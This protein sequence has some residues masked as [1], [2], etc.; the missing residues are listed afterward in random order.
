MSERRES[1][2]GVI[3]RNL[4]MLR[5]HLSD[6]ATAESIGGNA[7]HRTVDGVTYDCYAINGYANPKTGEVI[8]YGNDLRHANDMDLESFCLRIGIQRTRD[9]TQNYDRLLEAVSGE[10]NGTLSPELEGTLMA[11]KDAFDAESKATME[12]Y[13][14][15]FNARKAPTSVPMQKDAEKRLDWTIQGVI[16]SIRSCL[17]FGRKK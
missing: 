14:E 10:E 16:D 8:E 15:S 5:L 7:S 17:T 3:A 12:R 9:L 2:D 4:E 6:S 11:M 1:N 13:L